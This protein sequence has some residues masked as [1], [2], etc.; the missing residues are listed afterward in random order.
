MVSRPAPASAPADT[1]ALT[2]GDRPVS[3]NRPW[4][5]VTAVALPHGQPSLTPRTATP[6]AGRP[7]GPRTTPLTT[8]PRPSDSVTGFGSP[9]AGTSIATR[10]GSVPRPGLVKMVGAR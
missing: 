6:A 9:A 1:I 5:S 8:K 2:Y 10:G 3:S 7:S 4:A